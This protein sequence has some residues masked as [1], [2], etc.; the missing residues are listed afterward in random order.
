MLTACFSFYFYDR[1]YREQLH[2]ANQQLQ[3]LF[4]TV[5]SSAA[6]AAYLDNDEIALEVAR[7][8]SS[9]DIVSGAIVTSVTG[10]EVR[11]GS[12]IESTT[13]D[14]K[15]YTLDSPF[16]SGE[17]VGNITMLPNQALI[18]T[19]AR[20]AAW[21][22]VLIVSMQSLALVILA[23]ILVHRN[24]SAPIKK[25][26]GQLHL[27]PPGSM[28]RLECPK[29][30]AQDE[31]GLLVKDANTLLTATQNTLD[32]ERRLREYAESLERQFRL[33]FEK[34][35]CGIALVNAEGRILMYNPSLV[36]MLSDAST[37]PDMRS[38]P[39]H[40]FFENPDQVRA[41]LQTAYQTNSPV[42]SDL[43][44]HT[45]SADQSRWLN[46]LISKVTDDEGDMIVECIL[47]D[48]SERTAREKRTQFE[49]ERDPLTGLYNRRA[50][51]RKIESA[52]QHAKQTSS[53]CAF[54]LVDLDKFK[55][56]NDQYGHDAGDLVLQTISRRINKHL[57]KEDIVIRWGGD[58]F[59]IIVEHVNQPKAI[60][61]KLLAA[62]Q[63][64]ID[65]GNGNRDVVGASIGISLF[66]EHGQKIEDLV[67]RA[68][69]AMYR[70]KE[71]GRNHFSI[72]EK[73]R[74]DE[75]IENTAKHHNSLT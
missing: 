24:L 38:T 48:I 68:D 70:V 25:L 23:I 40:S 64:P 71:A 57:R 43:Q 50:G 33:I 5:E 2:S 8:L 22:H 26:A 12:A 15:T 28:E 55:P 46:S 36:E 62:L 30:H 35:S 11:G 45:K 42:T 39:F 61:E 29:G 66:P 47:Y 67:Q 16:M 1:T 17:I 3:Q 69:I 53:H 6:V 73:R 20:D 75:P 10:M 54:L 9:N 49:A 19:A 13:P 63:K 34:A 41:L 44:L 27:I 59:L 21:R 72:Y 60:A 65:L 4:N 18:K 14:L 56:I 32:G 37:S 52:L 31:I 74:G 51:Y 58:E 7:G